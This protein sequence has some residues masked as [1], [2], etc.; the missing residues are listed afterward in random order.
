VLK[1]SQP[2][3]RSEGTVNGGHG[4]GSHRRDM[5]GAPLLCLFSQPVDRSEGTVN[6]GHGCGSHRRDMDG[7]PLLC[8]GRMLRAR[9]HAIDEGIRVDG[10]PIT[11]A[12]IVE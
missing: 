3:D 8:L 1:F 4:C 5:D 12:P 7:A 11:N 10:H 9:L 2:V 6:G